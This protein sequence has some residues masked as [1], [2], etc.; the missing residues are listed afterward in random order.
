MAIAINSQKCRFILGLIFS[1][2][3]RM[4]SCLRTRISEHAECLRFLTL[5][6]F[7]LP[8]V[9]VGDDESRWHDITGGY[10]CALGKPHSSCVAVLRASLLTIDLK[11]HASTFHPFRSKTGLSW[12]YD[13]R[14]GNAKSIFL[15]YIKPYEWWL[16]VNVGVGVKFLKSS[17]KQ[18]RPRWIFFHSSPCLLTRSLLFVKLSSRLK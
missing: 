7:F 2:Y 9:Q 3:N 10:N 12:N 11:D 4:F 14:F 16:S 6:W 1:R 5:A 17:L 13:L 18:G 8:C 15:I